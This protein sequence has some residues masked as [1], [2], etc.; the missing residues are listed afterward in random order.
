MQ[1]YPTMLPDEGAGTS[2]SGGQERRAGNAT[3]A[4]TSRCHLCRQWGREAEAQAW[5]GQRPARLL[6]EPAGE[7][8]EW[9]NR[10]DLEN[11][12]TEIWWARC[13]FLCCFDK[14]VFGFP[15]Q[16]HRKAA[17]AAE[18]DKQLALQQKNVAIIA[19][20]EAQFQ[21]YARRVIDHCKKGG[22]NT[23][24]L[25]QA[26]KEGAGG[27]LGPVFPGKGGVRPSYMTSDHNGT[28]L[29]SYQGDSTD[30]VKSD[31]YGDGATMK[32]LGFVW[33]WNSGCINTKQDLF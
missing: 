26:A 12:S 22:R 18:R 23:Y 6:Y 1:H 24:P 25:Q 19:E 17:A 10:R 28:Q 9:A 30:S 29:P 11:A 3:N 4:P 33:W 7:L 14:T 5:G 32:R 16:N 8:W 13:A 2:Q 15:L 20:E 21:E 27:G 31:I